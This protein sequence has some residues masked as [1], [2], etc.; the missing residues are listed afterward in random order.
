MH[1]TIYLQNGDTIGITCDEYES[2]GQIIHL[3]DIEEPPEDGMARMEK[4][5]VVGKFWGIAGFV[6]S[7]DE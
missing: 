5:T 7:E 6:P 4:K 3:Y 1:V 2:A